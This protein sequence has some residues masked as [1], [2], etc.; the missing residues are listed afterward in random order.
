MLKPNNISL[1]N[2]KIR[3]I[4]CLFLLTMALVVLFIIY[5]LKNKDDENISNCKSEVKCIISNDDGDLLSN[6]TQ[7]I[8]INK[9]S[10]VV[11]E[12]GIVHYKSKKYII[13]RRMSLK[14]QERKSEHYTFEVQDLN[15]LNNDTLPSD[16]YHSLWPDSNIKI[17]HWQIYKLDDVTYLFVGISSAFQVCTV[18]KY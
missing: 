3:I 2:K 1:D 4:L 15:I 12:Q 9:D 6:Y 13:N 18:K 8:S 17:K 16:A 14:L 11:F 5:M 7:I 10:G